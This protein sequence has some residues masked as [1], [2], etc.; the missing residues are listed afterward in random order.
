ME[1]H[2]ITLKNGLRIITVPMTSTETVSLL[3][4]VSAGSRYEEKENNGIAHFLEHMFFK[5]T[6]KRPTALDISKEIDGV[7]GMMN[8]FTGVER[9]GYWVKVKNEHFDLALDVLSDI[10][11][12]S[13]FEEEEIEKEKGVIIEE[14]NMY[15]DDP[16]SYINDLMMKVFY[17]DQN[18]GRS[19]LGDDKKTIL[20]FSR[21]DF[22]NFKKRFYIPKNIVIGVAGKIDEEKIVES[23]KSYFKVEEKI[24]QE[25]IPF[26]PVIEKQKSPQSLVFYKKTDQA[27]ISL[28]FRTYSMFH[29]DRYVVD[30][31]GVIL[32]GGM[33]SRLFTEIRERRGWAYYINTGNF[34]FKETG[35][36]ATFAGLKLEKIYEAISLILNEHKKLIEQPITLEDLNK[37]RNY[38]KG[39]MALSL[40]DSMSVASFLSEQELLL[41][42]IETYEEICEKFDKI[43]IGDVQRVANDIFKNEKLNLAV[44]GPFKEK[45]KFEEVLKI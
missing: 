32:G 5:G 36:I 41:R 31:I 26:E 30:I 35:L 14:I 27:H 13:K 25:I 42:K 43:T 24:P 12:N 45:K 33:S 2:K 40:E 38:L 9:A 37:A 8:A 19:T 16:A 10:L 23:I 21:E 4:L 34:E 44:I 28:G 17:G 7:G 29:P 11:L 15:L 39:R 20:K 22:L 1:Y 18:L 3:I 6:K